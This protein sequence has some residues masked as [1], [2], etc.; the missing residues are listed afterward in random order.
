M[1]QFC[2]LFVWIN[3]TL[4]D[5]IPIDP[6]GAADNSTDRAIIS[7]M[8]VLVNGST[9]VCQTNLLA[10]S[11]TNHSSSKYLFVSAACFIT[12]THMLEY[13]HA[14]VWPLIRKIMNGALAI[15]KFSHYS[16][17]L[18]VL[19]HSFLVSISNLLNPTFWLLTIG[20]LLD[21]SSALSHWNPNSDLF[22]AGCAPSP[23]F[24]V[25]F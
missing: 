16:A 1:A 24:P 9:M 4:V 17:Q 25:K 6:A 15:L 19:F 23:S 2:T 12:H 5:F 21:I 14:Q 13:S 7:I 11:S 10:N 22:I 20:T 8:V 3:I 18:N